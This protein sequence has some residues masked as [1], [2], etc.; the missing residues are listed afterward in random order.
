MAVVIGSATTVVVDGVT[1]GFQSVNWNV[2]R[3][4][5]RL[6]QLGSFSPYNTQVAKTI[7]ASITTYAS[8][9]PT[10]TLAPADSCA[11]STA[12]KVITIDA[13]ACSGPVISFGYTMYVNS[14]SY[15]KGDATGFGTESWSFQYWEDSELGDNP[16]NT[17]MISVPDP[18]SV[19]QGIAEGSRFGDVGNGSTDLGVR[20][21][22]DQGAAPASKNHIVV[23]SQCSVSAGFPGTGRA[24]EVQL[25]L[26]E[27][28]G[29]GLLEAAGEIGQSNAT[30][31]HQ[32][33]YYG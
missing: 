18:E 21:V 4:P 6:W 3:Q 14:Y 24:D 26:I 22:D 11:D 20:F 10:V 25:G 29:G 5:T 1:D 23:G 9:L 15:S 32:P 13:Q 12:I 8:V 28:I 27:L 30:V 31:P 19:I 17:S 33:L 7:T 16:S 2:N